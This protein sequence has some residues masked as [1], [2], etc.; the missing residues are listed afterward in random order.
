MNI[1]R[2]K[3]E[4][5]LRYLR[6]YMGIWIDQWPLKLRPFDI[7]LESQFDSKA[8]K[9]QKSAQ[10]KQRSKCRYC[11]RLFDAYVEKT[12]DHVV[13]KSLGGYDLKEN[14]VPCCWDCNQWKNNK[15]MEEWI[16]ELKKLCKQQKARPPYTVGQLAIMLTNAKAVM[17]E[18]KKHPSKISIYKV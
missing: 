17:Q 1:K 3:P 7:W 18:A 5:R 16:K 8:S 10:Q 6:I 4:R 9:G 12:K 2:I 15:S 11:Q 14:R 13:A